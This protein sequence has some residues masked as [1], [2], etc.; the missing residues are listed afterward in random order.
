[1]IR[2]Y[3]P[4]SDDLPVAPELATLSVLDAALCAAAGV[5][6]M[7]HDIDYPRE[8]DAEIAADIARQARVLRALIHLYATAV[9]GDD[10]E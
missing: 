8:S 5:L 1:M 3:A 10:D 2:V 7:Q 6:Q 4:T 9:L